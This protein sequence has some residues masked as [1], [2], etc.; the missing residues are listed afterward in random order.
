MT[1]V[2]GQSV[3][4]HVTGTDPSDKGPFQLS[5]SFKRSGD[6]IAAPIFV[7]V[8]TQPNTKGDTTGY[9]HDTVGTCAAS[10]VTDDGADIVSGGGRLLGHFQCVRDVSGATAHQPVGE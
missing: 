6:T 9:D 5:L 10:G 1:L 7:D 3:I 2:K 8:A 4:F